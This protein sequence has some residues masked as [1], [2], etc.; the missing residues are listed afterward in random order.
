VVGSLTESGSLCHSSL[1]GDVYYAAQMSTAVAIRRLQDVP[2]RREPHTL[3]M[4]DDMGREFAISGRGSNTLDAALLDWFTCGLFTGFRLG[5]YAQD[6]YNSEI[7]SYKFNIRKEV[8]ALCLHDVRFES[9]ERG[10]FSAVAPQLRPDQTRRR[11]VRG[12]E[13]ARASAHIAERMPTTD[14]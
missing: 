2:T 9:A 8:Q 12:P 4:L 14:L 5:E 10:Q 11:D 3:E 7:T 1:D 13:W 6:A